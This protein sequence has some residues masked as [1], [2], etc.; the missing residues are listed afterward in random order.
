MHVPA[1]TSDLA[2]SSG[3]PLGRALWLLLSAIIIVPLL[4]FAGAASLSY[5]HHFRDAEDRLVRFLDVVHEHAVKVFETEELA[6]EQVNMLLEGLADA[7][8]FAR[9]AELNAKLKRLV[10]RLPQVNDV[11]VLDAAGRPLV[12]SNF[13]PAPRGLD[14]SDRAYF[15]VHRDGHIAP[16]AIYVSDILHGRADPTVR[17]FQMSSRREREG[18]FA[19]VTAV[20]LEPKYFEAF[21]QQAAR[22]GFDAVGLLREDGAFLARYPVR[23]D[24]PERL[25]QQGAFQR[26]IQRDASGG[27]FET[28]SAVDGVARLMAYRRLP[29]RPVYVTVG[30]SQA[31]VVGAWRGEMLSHLTYGVPATLGLALLTLLAIRRARRESEALSRLAQET[32]HRAAI[33]EQ[34]RQSQKM[35]A[36]GRLTGGIAHDFNNL[37]QIAIGSLDMLKRRLSDGDAR[38]RELR[39]VGAG[40]HDARRQPDPAPA[41]LRP[42]PAAGAEDGRGQSPGAGRL[43]AAAADAR[44]DGAHRDRA[45]RRPVDRLCRCQP[46]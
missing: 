33:E 13:M 12:T 23:A 43:R 39:A 8:V 44:R 4:V 27:T 40:G 21:Y 18:A 41:G 36:I 16:G 7:D 29:H 15:A 1:K 24:L 34:L 3:R 19:G 6:A 30:L 45:G 9:E 5:R 11:W 20:S 25:P 37:L 35:E 14:L 46:A 31:R 42:P 10:T 38:S 28:V 32:M 2:S 26:A 17:F 22:S